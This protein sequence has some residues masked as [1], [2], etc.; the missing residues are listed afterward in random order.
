[1]D[2]NVVII[3]VM[4]AYLVLMVGLGFFFKS[5]VNTFDDYIL[6]GRGLPWF[7]IAM[8]MLATLANAQQ[9]LGISGFSYQTGI[10][11]MLWFFIIVN[12]FIYP[13]IIR[14]GSRYRGMNFSTIV[15]L[16]EERFTGSKRLTILLSIWQVAWAVF[17][18]GICL[19]GGAL[20]IEAVFKIPMM[21][22]LAIA[23]IVT[24]V[25]T[26]LGGL[27]A[28]VFTDLIMWVIIVVGTAFFIPLVFAK[29]GTFT[30][31]FSNL[32]GPS[33]MNPVTNT[34]IWAGFT[35]MFTLAPGGMVTVKGILAMG[36]AGS[37]WIPID[38]GF[39][40]RMLAAKTITDG[41][42]ACKA[43]IVIVTVWATIMVALGMY[44]RVIY[45]GVTVT[46]TVVILLAKDAMPVF[47]TALF[48]TA[49][50]AA[51]VAFA[52]M[53]KSGGV[54][55]TA[56][57]IQMIICASLTP[58]VILSTYWHR[59]S[60]K[61]AFWGSIIS[62]VVTLIVTIQSGGGGAAFAGGGLWGIP[63][64]FIGLIVSISI[65]V[66][67]SL[68]TPYN[69]EK[70]GPKFRE[71]F[72]GKMDAD[73]VPNTD[74]KF[75]GTAV[76]LVLIA[77]IVRMLMNKPMGAFPP[78][79]GPFAWLTDGYFMAAAVAVFAVCIYVL[80]RSIGWVR[81]LGKED[82]TRSTEKNNGTL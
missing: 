18:T 3:S 69:P 19:F 41:R 50:A 54:F 16:A 57:T 2:E 80:I 1:M 10:S 45:P 60:E 82:S 62:G 52:P 31:F 66:I 25:Y 7:V 35:D 32:L 72:E 12:I 20:L 38:L 9:I 8:T 63:A 64:V 73:K 14:L 74:I 75:I 71:L 58:M 21:V 24:V 13:I 5:K 27:N 49:V 61:A 11:F 56:L 47:G 78:I 76:G 17:S 46:D 4:T 37:L 81:S 55:V 23:C 28:V 22:A 70:I 77:I 30:S 29:Y 15:D 44:G 34:D 51:A 6:G 67:M 36:I 33:G 65:Y 79:S 40:Q 26:I 42:K 39:V 53:V 68:L 48:L 43:F 59:M